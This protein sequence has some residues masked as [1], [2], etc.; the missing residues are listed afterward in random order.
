MFIIL[1]TYFKYLIKRKKNEEKK[2]SP[3]LGLE[4]TKV[5]TLEQDIISRKEAC[6][7][8][9]VLCNKLEL[10]VY[11]TVHLPSIVHWL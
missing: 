5:I 11:C 4:P 8:E 7:I 6:Y 10:V 9:F 1:F 3:R 2:K